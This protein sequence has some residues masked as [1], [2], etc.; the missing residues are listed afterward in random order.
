MLNSD[1]QEY[2]IHRYTS[3]SEDISIQLLELHSDR[4]K[5]REAPRDQSESH[6]F[7][8]GGRL[9]F[10]LLPNTEVGE[11]YARTAI[12]SGVIG[13][14]LCQTSRNSSDTFSW[15]LLAGIQTA[16]VAV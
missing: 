9:R 6:P 5:G 4:Y 11:L 12:E 16:L 7:H 10:S 15:R 2:E 13:F 8:S 14:Q 1:G 3:M